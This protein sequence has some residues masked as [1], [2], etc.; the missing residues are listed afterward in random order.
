MVFCKVHIH[1]RRRAAAAVTA[2]AALGKATTLARTSCRSADHY[3]LAGC[4]MHSNVPFFL[5]FVFFEVRSWGVGLQSLKYG[6]PLVAPWDSQAL[7]ARV[8]LQPPVSMI[9]LFKH[10]MVL[11]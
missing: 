3:I 11:W 8:E 4:G 1:T 5:F 2:A 9:Q 7:A 6:S 10:H